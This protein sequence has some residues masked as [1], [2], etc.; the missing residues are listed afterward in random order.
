MLA[1]GWRAFGGRGD[2]GGQALGGHV[3]LGESAF[4]GYGDFRGRGFGQKGELGEGAFG[5]Q[6]LVRAMLVGLCGG[7]VAIVG[8]GTWMGMSRVVAATAAVAHDKTSVAC[9]IRLISGGIVVAFGGC[10]IGYSVVGGVGGVSM[11]A[12]HSQAAE[13]PASSLSGPHSPAVAVA[14]CLAVPR[15]ILVVV[16]LAVPPPLLGKK[17]SPPPPPPLLGTAGGKMPL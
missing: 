3:D 11:L 12:T 17:T 5:G 2:L 13:E 7:E 4:V 16:A 9:H 15:G 1:F 14:G 8:V 10:N 6:A